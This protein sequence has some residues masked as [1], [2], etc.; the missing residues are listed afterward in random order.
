MNDL[1]ESLYKLTNFKKDEYKLDSVKAVASELNL[2]NF[3]CKMIHVAGTNGKGSVCYKIANAL[4]KSGIKTGVFSSPHIS[5][6]RERIQVD[7]KLIEEEFAYSMIQEILD[8][9]QTKKIVPTFFEVMTL[10]ALFYFRMKKVEFV[11]METG[12]GGRL[13]ATNIISPI[14]TI[15]TSISLDHTLILGDTIEKIALEKAGIIKPLI[16]LILGTSSSLFPI[17]QTAK[18]KK[19][20][21]FFI[22]GTFSSF[23]EENREIAYKALSLLEEREGLMITDTKR[24]IKDSPPCRFEIKGHVVFDV[25]HN[26]KGIIEL[27]KALKNTFSQKKFR[28]LLAL[29]KD[30]EKENILSLIS[31]KASFIHPICV[32]ERQLSVK[33][34]CKELQNLSFEHFSHKNTSFQTIQEAYSLSLLRNEILVVTGSFFHMHEVK[35]SL[36]FKEKKD[37][38]DLNEKGFSGVLANKD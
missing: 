16:P 24:M 19:A 29:S 10:L 22:E 13:D 20:P 26:E 38:I 1:I 37:S 30:K 33:E 18:E 11:L 35:T 17:I 34:I 36:G 5:T 3:P 28:F 9:Y 27:L 14:L 6:F 4:T 8:F 32:S 23:E 7:Q 25:A 31:E 2:L 15:I 21:I 12:L